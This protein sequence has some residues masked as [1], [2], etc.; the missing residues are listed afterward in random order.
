MPI[1]RGAVY[2]YPNF[3]ATVA[4]V[5]GATALEHMIVLL[6]DPQRMDASATGAAF[7]VCTRDTTGGRKLED[8]EIP[9]G[10]EDDLPLPTIVDCRWVFTGDRT[11]FSNE[12]LY[13]TRLSDERMVL[14]SEAIYCGLQLRTY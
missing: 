14:I 5:P 9:L 1:A 2:W 3:R 12:V 10:P 7:V 11:E 13:V 6:Q 8:Y 4:G